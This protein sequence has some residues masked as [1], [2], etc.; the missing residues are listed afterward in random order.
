MEEQ[1]FNEESVEPVLTEQRQ[2]AVFQENLPNSGLVLTLGIL[3]IVLTCC[4]G[5]LTL[6]LSIIGW[7][8]GNKGVAKYNM[9]PGG[10]TRSSYSN[11]NA[12]RICAI[13]GFVLAVIY[14]LWFFFSLSQI[15]GW[16]AYMEKVNE[17]M[18]QYQ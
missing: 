17:A 10:Y 1:K 8:M 7:I 2:E 16:D 11:L 5:P 3:S 12:G 4:C 6:P 9:N 13:I 14:V 15:G 18:E